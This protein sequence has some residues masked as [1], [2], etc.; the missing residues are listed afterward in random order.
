[1]SGRDL[2]EASKALATSI[3]RRQAVRGFGGVIAASVLS[4]FGSENAA[5][6]DPGRCR[7]VGV[8]C[9]RNSECCS[10]LCDPASGRCACQ[11][12]STLCRKSGQCIFCPGGSVLNQ[13]TCRCECPAGTQTCGGDNTCCPLDASCC[14]NIANQGFCC[15]P[16]DTTCC[17]NQF[18]SALGCCPT[19]TTCCFDPNGVLV[20][21]CSQGQTCG[22]FG[23]S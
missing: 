9:R 11:P 21:C 14:V 8:I 12:G 18:G 17:V 4:L 19:G 3:S 20:G 5:A 10:D 6:Q 1:M 23:C 16:P 13:N 2:D 22:F 15:S 7:K